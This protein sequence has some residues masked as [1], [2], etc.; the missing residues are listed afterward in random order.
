M[1]VTFQPVEW[2]A[3]WVE[4]DAPL[5]DH[6]VYRAVATVTAGEDGEAY[7]RGLLSCAEIDAIMWKAFML[8]AKVHGINTLIGRRFNHGEA[9]PFRMATAPRL[10]LRMK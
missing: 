5:E 4:S 6:G 10:R 1:I 3:R 8:T 2:I 7:V 9:R